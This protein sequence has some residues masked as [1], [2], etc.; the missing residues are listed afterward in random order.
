[1]S[2][3]NVIG[4]DL[5]KNVFELSLQNRTGR[6]VK[7]QRLRRAKL[8]P[9]L[10]QYPPCLVGLEACGGA[11]DWARRIQTLGHR[12]RLLPPQYVKGYLIGTKNDAH[13]A[14]AIA[15]AATRPHV[16][17]VAVKSPEQ[18]AL[19]ALHRVR[20]QAVKQ[21]TALGNCARGLL[22]EFGITVRKGHAPLR[23]ALAEV[24]D[25]SD[26]PEPLKLAV[27][28]LAESLA[29]LRAQITHLTTAIERAASHDAVSCRLMQVP[30]VGPVTATAFVAGVGD[31]RVFRNAR[32]VPAWLGLVPRQASS[33]DHQTLLSISKRGDRYLRGLLVHGARAV[34]KTARHK[35]DRYSRWMCAVAERRGHN[36][37]V[38]AIANK[39]ARILWAMMRSGQDYR[40]APAMTA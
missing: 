20:Q 19:Q 23:R 3:I 10:A 32:Q 28:S 27:Q 39:N 16:P 26:L 1:M 24:M 12:V 6:V 22:A 11:H 5:A 9:T 2:E 40:P 29:Q 17:E 7:R 33:G 15:E 36:K 30:G 31:A 37:A 38:V 8:L 25:A 35:S 18:L 34:L 14:D 13:D 4:I 21:H